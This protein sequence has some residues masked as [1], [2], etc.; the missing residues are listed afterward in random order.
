MITY[1]NLAEL[2]RLWGKEEKAKEYLY[3][4]VKTAQAIDYKNNKENINKF[5]YKH[6]N[7]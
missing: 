5:I 7:F 4:T 2:Y 6:E 3:L 1:N